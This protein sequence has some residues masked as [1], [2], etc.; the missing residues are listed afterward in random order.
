MIFHFSSFSLRLS[1]GQEIFRIGAGR[2]TQKIQPTATKHH[3]TPPSSS[4][5]PNVALPRQQMERHPHHR[6]RRLLLGHNYLPP[7]LRHSP[8]HGN[9]SPQK[10]HHCG[11]GRFDR[12]TRTVRCVTHWRTVCKPI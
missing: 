6:S 3:K 12:S 5:S 8:S 4:P 7:H 1:E 11:R 10:Y 9:P 2:K